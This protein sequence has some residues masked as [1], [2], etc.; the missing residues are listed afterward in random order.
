M[1]MQC[2]ACWD[3][4]SVRV[5]L[6]AYGH[7]CH[8]MPLD[9]ELIRQTFCIEVVF[10]P[11]EAETYRHRATCERVIL[12]PSSWPFSMRCARWGLTPIRN[13]AALRHTTTGLLVSMPCVGT[14][15]A[16]YCF[17]RI[18]YLR[19]LLGMVCVPASSSTGTSGRIS[20]EGEVTSS[21]VSASGAP[22]LVSVAFSSVL[23]GLVT[24]S[25]V[26]ASGAPVLVSVALSSLLEGLV[27]IWHGKMPQI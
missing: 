1:R 19:L 14:L 6:G 25:Q 12:R 23:E 21:Q 27:T 20:L 17:L 9:G 15:G 4:C 24:S 26:S 22:V 2:R 3:C 13:S 10:P 8:I 7:A 16:Q 11:E 18:V 5:T